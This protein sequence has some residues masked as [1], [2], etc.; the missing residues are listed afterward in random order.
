MDSASFSGVNYWM[1]SDYLTKKISVRG[2]GKRM[3]LSYEHVMQVGRWLSLMM[4]IFIMPNPK[5]IRTINAMP[6]PN[7]LVKFCVVNMERKLFPRGLA[8]ASK[9]QC[10]KGFV[11]GLISSKIGII[12]YIWEKNIQERGSFLSCQS[13]APEGARMSSV[14]KETQC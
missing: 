3:T 1:K 14:A 6:Y 2:T 11:Q 12:A 10:W 7:A 8:F 5:A 13:I 4:Y 9:I